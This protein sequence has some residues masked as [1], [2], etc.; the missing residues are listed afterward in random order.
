MIAA[1]TAVAACAILVY[2]LESGGQP[3]KTGAPTEAAVLRSLTPAQ[4]QYVLGM[5]SLAPAQLHAAFGTVK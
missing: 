5:S 1:V 2:I 3:A 4:L